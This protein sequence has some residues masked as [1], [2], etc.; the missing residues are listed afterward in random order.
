MA[1]PEFDKSSKKFSGRCCVEG[2]RTA[3]YAIS[4]ELACPP[5]VPPTLRSRRL[6][7]EVV[8]DRILMA[9]LAGFADPDPPPGNHFGAA[10][11]VL[12][13]GNVVVTQGRV[14]VMVQGYITAGNGAS[15]SVRFTQDLQLRMHRDQGRERRLGHSQGDATRT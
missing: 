5:G 12:S 6:S 3:L 2:V 11:I 13:T 1:G 9:G 4:A 7:W 10:V 15:N 14:K 8:E